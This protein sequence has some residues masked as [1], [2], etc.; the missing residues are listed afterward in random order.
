MSNESTRNAAD[1]LAKIISLVFHPLFM[2]LY[3]LGILFSSPT[4]LGYVP[5]QV[6]KIMFLIVLMNNV[7]VPLA[8]LPFFRH[9]NIISSYS[10]EERS[11]RILPLVTGSVLY[12]I[13]TFIFLRFP[14]PEFFKSFIFAGAIIV[15]VLT[16]INFR[17]KISI[18]GASAGAITALVIV[19]ALKSNATLT[20]YL[21]SVITAGGLILTSRLRLNSHNPCQVWIGFLTGLTI[22]GLSLWFL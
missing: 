1:T 5:F 22:S 14:V 16:I 3:G 21:V 13:T 18:H 6:K 9:R 2:P 7:L 20:F 19:L 17:W 11:E 8:L 4:S 10:I 12:I 15:V